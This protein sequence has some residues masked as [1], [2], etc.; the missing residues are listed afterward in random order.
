[1]KPVYNDHPMGHFSAFWTLSRATWISSRRQKLLARVNSYLQ[2]GLK[3]ITDQITTNEFYYRGARYRQVSLYFPN[4]YYHACK[5]HVHTYTYAPGVRT[6]YMCVCV[7][8][9]CLITWC[10]N[11]IYMCVLSCDVWM[12]ICW[13]FYAYS[14]D[15]K[16]CQHY[17]NVI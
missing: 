16:V 14:Q 3:H 1:M 11:F 8:H 6:P 10:L 12:R 4:L 5:T 13:W 17:I 9:V 2:S 7:I 15:D